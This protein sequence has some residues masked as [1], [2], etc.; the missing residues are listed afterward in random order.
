[1]FPGEGA[2]H[3]LAYAL[4]P[5]RL[6]RREAGRYSPSPV[7][8][9]VVLSPGVRPG[10]LHGAVLHYSV[11]SLGDQIAKLNRYTDSQADDL[12]AR[13]LRV[14]A[15]RLFVEFPLNFLKAYVLRRHLVRGTYG[16]MTAMNYAYYRWLRVAKALA[17]ERERP[18]AGAGEG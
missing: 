12:A 6:Y 13:G 4:Y 8:D 7:H 1:M 16:F 11:R 5:V 18:R 9:R 10:R 2:P 14:P 15:W 3:P 17:R